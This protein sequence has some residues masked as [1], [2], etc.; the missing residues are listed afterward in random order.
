MFT[1]IRVPL[2]GWFHP[3]GE[4]PAVNLL[5]DLPV[6]DGEGTVN[7]LSLACRT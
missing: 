2:K 5:Q 1:P 3:I 4:T 6:A 7:V